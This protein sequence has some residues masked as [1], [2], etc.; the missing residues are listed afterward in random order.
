MYIYELKEGK[1]KQWQQMMHGE[2]QQKKKTCLSSRTITTFDVHTYI[3]RTLCRKN[4]ENAN[5]GTKGHT[6][7]GGGGGIVRERESTRYY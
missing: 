6:K 5:F 2:N 1:H 3:H 7:G 4:M